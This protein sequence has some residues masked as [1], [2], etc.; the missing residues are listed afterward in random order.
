M[1]T[2][3]KIEVNPSTHT[4]T[5]PNCYHQHLKWCKFTAEYN[6]EPLYVSCYKIF[7]L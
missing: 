7:V 3:N 4:Y 6:I 5:K 1:K 2:R